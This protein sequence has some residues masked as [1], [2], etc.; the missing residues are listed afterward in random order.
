[1]GRTRVI[2][3]L[4][5]FIYLKRDPPGGFLLP[6]SIKLAFGVSVP[7]PSLSPASTLHM[8]PASESPTPSSARN[9]ADQCVGTDEVL[10]FPRPYHPS[11]PCIH[12]TF[13]LVD[14]LTCR[15]CI[16]AAVWGEV[17]L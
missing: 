5:A 9:E 4:R 17:V 8:K 6:G 2:L 11:K 10:A 15:L 13:L 12:P 1:M 7:A 16:G 3:E 14:I